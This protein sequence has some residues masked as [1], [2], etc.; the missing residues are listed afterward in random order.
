M[1][2]LE[3]ESSWDKALSSKDRIEIE[4]IFLV[5]SKI[6]LNHVHLSP[7][8]QAI[9]HRGELLMTVLVHNFT[10]QALTFH[11]KKLVCIE[12]DEVIAEFPFTLPTLLVQP[13]VSMPWTFIFPVDSLKSNASLTNSRLEIRL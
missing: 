8:W 13:K 2:K 6:D 3:F 9:N 11:E 4:E 7:I 1:Q 12:N 10:H 5:T